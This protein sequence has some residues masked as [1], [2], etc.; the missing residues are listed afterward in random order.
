MDLFVVVFIFSLGILR[1]FA[2]LG[3]ALLGLFGFNG[4]GKQT[5]KEGG[6]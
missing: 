1:S 6:N 2:D 4:V 5:E 3:L